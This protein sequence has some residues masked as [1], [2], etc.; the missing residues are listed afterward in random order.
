MHGRGGM[1]AR[2]HAWQG[3]MCGRGMS[4]SGGV[5]G[6]RDGHC[7]GGRHPTGMYSCCQFR[8]VCENLDGMSFTL[9][10]TSVIGEK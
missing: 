5:C 1:C 4:G 3:G 7:I 6:R 9:F 8:L 10:M 2:G